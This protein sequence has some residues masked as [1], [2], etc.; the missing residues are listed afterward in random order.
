MGRLRRNLAAI[1]SLHPNTL[2]TCQGVCGFLKPFQ[3]EF[4]RYVVRVFSM[5]RAA[6]PQD[7][8]GAPG[9]PTTSQSLLIKSFMCN[10]SL[11]VPRTAASL[12]QVGVGQW[13]PCSMGRS[14]LR[15]VYSL[16]NQGH[17]FVL[18]P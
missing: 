4:H 18:V 13:W 3:C 8:D 5:G 17:S 9:L 7:A 14:D 6:A 10:R 15:P 16:G 1:G 2:Y 11:P 12:P